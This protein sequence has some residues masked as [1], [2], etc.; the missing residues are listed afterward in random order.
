MEW[1]K[2]HVLESDRSGFCHLFTIHL[3]QGTNSSK[4]QILLCKMDMRVSPKT[5]VKVK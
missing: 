1:L 3:G 2:A 4:I 5:V